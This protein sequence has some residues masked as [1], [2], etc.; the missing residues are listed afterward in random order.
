MKMGPDRARR[1]ELLA[2]YER[3][4][5]LL[6]AAWQALPPEARTW[7]PAPGHWSALEVLG[8][9]ADAEMHAAIRIRALLAEEQPLIAGYDENRWAQVLD[10]HG[11][12]PVQAFAVIEAANRLTAALLA[13]LA[14]PHF[15]RAGTHTQSG[16]YADA[17]WFRIYAEHL[18]IHARQIARNHEQ[19]QSARA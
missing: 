4:P 12:D 5:A 18:E 19:W 17:D 14:D 7:R 13:R 1:M 8:H 11:V 6:G 10:Y 15:G 9:C 2:R 16:P 3:G